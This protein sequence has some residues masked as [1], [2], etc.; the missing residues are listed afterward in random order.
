MNTVTIGNKTNLSLS[1][2]LTLS[3]L[4]LSILPTLGLIKFHSSRHEDSIILITN[5][6][7][8]IKQ[9]S[10]SVFNIYMYEL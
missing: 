2:C 5:A 6:S 7:D 4:K 9:A 3:F 10:Y 8:K 1:T